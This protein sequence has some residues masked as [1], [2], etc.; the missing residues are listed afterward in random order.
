MSS[1]QWRNRKVT[2]VGAGAVGATFAYALAN[3]GLADEIALL[4]L[5]LE[6]AEGQV[7]D[8]AHG[9]PFFPPVEIHVGDESGTHK[10]EGPD[11]HY[12]REKHNQRHHNHYPPIVQRPVQYLLVEPIQFL[13]TQSNLTG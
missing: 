6:L 5:N 8:L 11:D 4:D 7:L 2:I 1:E 12:T 9:T 3:S 13:H 10:T